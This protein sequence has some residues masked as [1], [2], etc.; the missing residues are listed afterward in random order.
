VLRGGVSVPA[1]AY[2]L[3]LDL[4]ARGVRLTRDGDALVVEP[5]NRLTA[6]DHRAIPVLKGYLLTVVD[7]DADAHGTLP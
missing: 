7:Y 4:E 3:A 5:G 2:R 6:E 1:D